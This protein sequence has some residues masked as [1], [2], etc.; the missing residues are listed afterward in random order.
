MCSIIYQLTPSGIGCGVQTVQFA[1]IRLLSL[2]VVQCGTSPLFTDYSMCMPASDI[3]LSIIIYIIQVVV[4]IEIC[5][6]N[7]S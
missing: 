7:N 3:E 4:E 6:L 1:C 5:K 2:C